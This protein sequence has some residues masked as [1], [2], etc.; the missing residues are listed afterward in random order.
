[1][2]A[3]P[4]KPAFIAQLENLESSKRF[5]PE[6]LEAIYAMARNLYSSGRYDQATRYFGLLTM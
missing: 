1:M 4:A 2:S 5:T 6:Q 3:K